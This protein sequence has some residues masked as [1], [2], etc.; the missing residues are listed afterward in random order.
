MKEFQKKI[1]MNERMI[2]QTLSESS[3]D[4]GSGGQVSVAPQILAE[5]K[6]A[7]LNAI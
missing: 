7:T 5:Y 2:N 6:L 4:G 1:M 3:R